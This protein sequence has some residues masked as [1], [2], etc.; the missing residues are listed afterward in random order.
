MSIGEPYKCPCTSERCRNPGL[1][2]AFASTSSARPIAQPRTAFA[3]ATGRTADT[4]AISVSL[5]RSRHRGHQVRH[6]NI[7]AAT[8]TGC[9]TLAQNE[10]ASAA[11]S[12]LFD[13]RRNEKHRQ[14]LRA[15]RGDQ[16]FDFLFRADVDA[17]RWLIEHDKVRRG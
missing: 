9:A 12:D 13:L 11:A 3:R 14:T 6:G 1:N 8:L 5:M 16:L 17:A 10:N 7:F 15:E 4:A 2:I